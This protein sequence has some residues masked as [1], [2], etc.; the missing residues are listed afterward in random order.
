MS[1]NCG[2]VTAE[3]L[4]GGSVFGVAEQKAVG[5]GGS[6][7]GEVKR[8]GLDLRVGVECLGAQLAAQAALLVASERQPAVDPVGVVDPHAAGL[9]PFGHCE[10][11][12]IVTAPDARGQTV[13]AVVGDGDRFVVRVVGDHG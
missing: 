10:R 9:N 6:S 4:S 3:L 1:S 2:A 13:V 8:H 11:A 5:F 7:A 12:S